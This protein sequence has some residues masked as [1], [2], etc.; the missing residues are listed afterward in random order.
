MLDRRLGLARGFNRGTFTAFPEGQSLTEVKHAPAWRIRESGRLR[1]Q[2]PTDKREACQRQHRQNGEENQR[3]ILQ[4]TAVGN[5]DA[6]QD[7][8]GNK[9]KRNGNAGI[10]KCFNHTSGCVQP[11]QPQVKV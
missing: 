11:G 2:E 9:V 6:L 4:A 7:P 5:L 10:S 3:A 8:V 1:D